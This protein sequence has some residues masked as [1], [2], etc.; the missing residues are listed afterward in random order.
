[1]GKL[2]TEEVKEG[3]LCWTTPKT[4]KISFINISR[5]CPFF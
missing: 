5:E 2:L 4:E 3:T 1:M